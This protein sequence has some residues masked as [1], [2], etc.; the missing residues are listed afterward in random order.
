MKKEAAKDHLARAEAAFN[1]KK[2]R[3]G[4]VDRAKWRGD[5]WSGSAEK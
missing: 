1:N 3:M 4:V 2:N 5:G